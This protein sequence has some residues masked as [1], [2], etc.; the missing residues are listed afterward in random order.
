MI[1]E[2]AE[3]LQREALALRHLEA[4]LR[5]LEL[6]VAA[7]EQ[8]FVPLALE[9][10]EHASEQVAGLELAR[11]LALSTAGYGPDVRAEA[12]AGA[13]EDGYLANVV[14]ELRDAFQG[15]DDARQRAV[16]VVSRAGNE[17]RTRI[18]AANAFAGFGGG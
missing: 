11:V 12:L 6:V 15:V 16:A 18:A 14:D 1:D 10:L 5:A 3:L 17:T 4:R 2:L 13:G 8:R 9:E 7:D